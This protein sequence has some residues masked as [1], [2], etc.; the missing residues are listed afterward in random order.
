M[1]KWT[2]A[3]CKLHVPVSKKLVDTC[4]RPIVRQNSGLTILFVLGIAMFIKL[5]RYDY[6]RWV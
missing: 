3:M 1:I 5:I 4:T 6:C 2:F